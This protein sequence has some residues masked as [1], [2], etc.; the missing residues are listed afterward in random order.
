MF[1]SNE[2]SLHTKNYS[3]WRHCAQCYQNIIVDI[4]NQI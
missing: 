2:K 3:E 1:K 4:G